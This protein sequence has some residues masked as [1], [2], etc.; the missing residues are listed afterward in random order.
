M[1]TGWHNPLTRRAQYAQGMSLFITG[2]PAIAGVFDHFARQGTFNENRLAIN[3]CNAAS[4]MIQGFDM[5]LRH[6]KWLDPFGKR[7]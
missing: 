2:L 1:R 5:C 7:M 4:F 3:M 6:G